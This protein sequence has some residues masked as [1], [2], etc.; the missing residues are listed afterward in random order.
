MVEYL[1][2]KNPNVHTLTTKRRTALH[3]AAK[4][5]HLKCIEVLLKFD[6]DLH[7]RDLEGESG[8]LSFLFYQIPSFNYFDYNLKY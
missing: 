5:G 3:L 6:I 7:A 4:A 1:L 2:E 8:S